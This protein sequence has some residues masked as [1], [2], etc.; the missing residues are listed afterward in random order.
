MIAYPRITWVLRYISLQDDQR[1]LAGA[2]A[3]EV[4]LSC[5]TSPDKQT[6]G[7]KASRFW[8]I[9]FFPVILSHSGTPAF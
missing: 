1:G 6:L 7:E 5:S 8:F 4:L 3:E 9:L 2:E